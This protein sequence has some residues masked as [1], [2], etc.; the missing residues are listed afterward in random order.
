LRMWSVLL[1]MSACACKMCFTMFMPSLTF[2]F[3]VIWRDLHAIASYSLPP[4]ILP[5]NSPLFFLFRTH[6]H[7]PLSLFH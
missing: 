6:G 7:S 5:A 4:S 2:R 3:I 1:S